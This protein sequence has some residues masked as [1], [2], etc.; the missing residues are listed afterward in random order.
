[1]VLLDLRFLVRLEAGGGDL[2]GL[3]AEQVELLG[4]G[5]LV[6]DQRGLLRFQGGAA[7]DEFGEG[8]AVGVQAA[9]GIED[10]ELPGRVEQG[11][12][13]VRAVDVHQPFAEG[14]EDGQ[15]GGRAVDELAVGAGGW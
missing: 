15:R 7:A 9:E 13:I 8:L 12:V 11:L 1:M 14:G 5:L 6:H 2:V 4:V 3:K 10:G